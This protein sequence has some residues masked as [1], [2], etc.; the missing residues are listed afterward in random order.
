[1]MKIGKRIWIGP[2]VAALAVVA[3]AAADARADEAF[4]RE[5]LK[6]MSDYLAAQAT[7]AVDFDADLEVMTA[8]G[9]KLLLASSGNLVMA[10]PDKLHVTRASGFA[11]AELLFDGATLTLLGRN[12]NV[13]A[14]VEAAGTIDQLVDTLRDTYGRPL[15]AADLLLSDVHSALMEGVTD[16]KD[17]GS[18]VIAG[19]ECDHFAARAEQVDWQIWITQDAMPLPCRYV[20]TSREVQGGPQ[21]SILFR[22]WSTNEAVPPEQFVFSNATG[23]TKVELKDMAES[24]DLPDHFKTGANP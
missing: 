9:Q 21:Y 1:M 12:A 15:P 4:A 2:S 18:G 17:L 13:Y 23:A 24:R 7:L 8:D 3:I 5:R 16:V 6:A 20:I 10:R 22:N 19:R 14:Q 11:D